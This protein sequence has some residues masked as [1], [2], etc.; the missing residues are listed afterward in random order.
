MKNKNDTKRKTKTTKKAKHEMV[1]QIHHRHMRLGTY[2]LSS[3][4]R[5]SHNS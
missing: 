4:L 3:S 1:P 2:N 5:P